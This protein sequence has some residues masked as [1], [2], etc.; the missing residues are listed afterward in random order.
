MSGISVEQCEE[1]RRKFYEDL[2]AGLKTRVGKWTFA[3]V[4]GSMATL[5]L[6]A[7]SYFFAT[8]NKTNELTARMEVRQQT[9]QED[10][11]EIKEL[12]RNGS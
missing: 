11:K 3:L 12:I 2:T 1:H 7:A 9:I 10:V 5:T 6:L 8:T 4:V